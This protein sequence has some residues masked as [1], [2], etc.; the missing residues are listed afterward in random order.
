MTVGVDNDDR[1]GPYN[2]S[3]PQRHADENR[4]WKNGLW[5]E[6]A[7]WVAVARSNAMVVVDA[8]KSSKLPTLA[9]FSPT[10]FR[11]LPSFVGF[12]GTIHAPVSCVVSAASSC[13]RATRNG[14]AV[15][16]AAVSA[17]KK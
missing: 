3:P 4:T 8:E 9:I 11:P 16:Q 6:W 2:A 12:H 17:S 14:H 1:E 13:G 15:R 5:Y 10:P 7:I